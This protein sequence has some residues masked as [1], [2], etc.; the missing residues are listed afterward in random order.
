MIDGT[1][2]RWGVRGGTGSVGFR[3]V[4][5]EPSEAPTFGEQVQDIEGGALALRGIR[6]SRRLWA[7]TTRSRNAGEQL[8]A[9]STT[10]GGPTLIHGGDFASRRWGVSACIGLHRCLAD[11]QLPLNPARVARARSFKPPGTAVPR[12]LP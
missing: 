12:A 4:A 6:H 2:L 7:R 11:R 1:P 9:A 10:F 5:S 3:Y 8:A